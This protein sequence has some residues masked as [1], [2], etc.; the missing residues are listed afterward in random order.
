[1]AQERRTRGRMS[2][3]K[4]AVHTPMTGCLPFDGLHSLLLDIGLSSTGTPK[5][6]TSD[7]VFQPPNWR[8]VQAGRWQ[9]RINVLS[10]GRPTMLR[11]LSLENI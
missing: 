2:V 9:S 3:P 5:I 10:L 6:S 8:A 4:P 7:L 11:L 1:M